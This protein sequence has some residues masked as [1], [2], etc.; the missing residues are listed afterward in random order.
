M[1]LVE[2]S[3]D[4]HSDV[5]QFAINSQSVDS[6]SVQLSTKPLATSVAVDRYYLL[7]M[8]EMHLV[9]MYFLFFFAFPG[10]HSR[11]PSVH[12][13]QERH[14]TMSYIVADGHWWSHVY[15]LLKFIDRS[16]ISPFWNI[17][18]NFLT[19][20]VY[21]IYF[22]F[23]AELT[24]I[25]E[26]KSKLLAI[27]VAAHKFIMENKDYDA[28]SLKTDVSDLYVIWHECHSR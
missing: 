15:K 3:A 17:H 21:S 25:V 10:D 9:I 18:C 4:T 13:V 11:V 19:A 6:N 2:W 20:N 28:S 8:S 22:A 23:Q 14:S 5:I 27:N 7:L 12:L 24:E 26:F 1:P 16:A